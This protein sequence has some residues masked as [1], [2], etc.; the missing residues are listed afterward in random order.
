MKSHPLVVALAPALLALALAPPAAA[1]DPPTSLEFLGELSLLPGTMHGGEAVGG[2]SGLVWDEH[3]RLFV[4]LADDRGEKAPPR[5]YRLRLD[6]AE[7][8]RGA[9]RG[10]EIVERVRL[11]GADGT[12]YAVGAIDPEGLARSPSGDLF[13][14]TEGVARDGI[15]PFVARLDAAGREA[16]RLPLPERLAPDAGGRRGVRDNLGLE[17]LTVTPDGRWLVAGIENAVAG[18]GPAAD[19]GV[20]SPS[21]LLAW[22]LAAPAAPREYL[23]EVGPVTQALPRPDSYRVNGLVDLVAFAPDRLWALEREFV[24]GAGLR[25][26]LYEVRLAPSLAE[27]AGAAAGRAAKRLL[28]EFADLGV[29]LDNF[30]GMTLGPPLADG[31]RAFVVVS[32]DN[33]NPLLQATRF[34]V[35]AADWAPPTIAAIQGAGH[36]SPLA[37]RWVLGV[38]AVVT[39]VDGEART[40]SFFVESETPDGDAATSEGL[41]VEW[42]RAGE[43]AAGDRV[44]L[45]GRVVERSPGAKQL[46]VTTLVA[47]DVERSARGVELPAAP[48]VGSELRV[49]P[50]IDDDGLGVFE[51]ARDAIDFWESLEGMRVVADGRLVTGPTSGYGEL[52]LALDDGAGGALSRAGGHLLTPAGPRQDRV[53][54]SGRLVGGLPQLAV[55]SRLGAPVA[56]VVDYSFSNYKIVATRPLEVATESTACDVRTAFWRQPD[57]LRVAAFN[58][59]NLS[60]ADGGDR[61]EGLAEA[62]VTRLG[63]P[64]VLALSEIQDDSGRQGGDGVV[65]ARGTLDRLTAA[66]AAAGGP[67]YEWVQI[68]PELDREGGVPGGNIRV[69]LLFDPAR[70]TLPRRGEAG[71]LDAARIAAGEGGVALEPNPARVAPASPAFTLASGEGVRRSLV[72]EL[73]VDGA[74]W[75]FVANHWSSKFDDS[76]PYGAVQPPERPTGAKRQAQAETIR[77]FALEL[78][79]ADPRARLVVLGDLNDLPWSEPI[80]TLV[81]PPLVDLTERV[82]AESRYSYNFE[83]AA[84]LI[85]QFVVSPALAGDARVEIVH[86]N[87]D[88]PD[89]AR[90]SDHDAVLASLAAALR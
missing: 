76:R 7:V 84:Q 48:L 67:T 64:E 35:F 14:S 37:G 62:I 47:A 41:R 40:P 19:V 63:A 25:L 55:G 26:R 83:G 87:S 80:R 3:E 85:D 36:R 59:E 16:A 18:D 50:T 24:M 9:G 45:H 15:A 79:A 22:E 43:L 60:L 30:E 90:T 81:A 88:C 13:L 61:F 74:P 32:D 21:R 34:L 8:G 38:E 6:F 73:T 70:A 58:V 78:L 44:R 23:Y 11:G 71:P 86:L 57:R 66:I 12:G 20:P 89:A 1:D 2:L 51:P 28:V 49:P 4:A 29:V 46:T 82:P 42:A 27:P 75:Y 68:D 69:A 53:L 54:V 65:T 72:V 33:F 31:R 10:V 52:V 39:A 56:G 5:F 17:S 77:A